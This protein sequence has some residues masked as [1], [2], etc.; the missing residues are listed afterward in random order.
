[1]LY[2]HKAKLRI[3]IQELPKNLKQRKLVIF[4]NMFPQGRGGAT[5]GI[6]EK[7]EL[8]HIISSQQV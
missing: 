6:I 5:D 3:F 7:A 1:M 8:F 4:F 2:T